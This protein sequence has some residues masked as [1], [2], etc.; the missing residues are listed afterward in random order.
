MK[1]LL[2]IYTWSTVENKKKNENKLVVSSRLSLAESRKP[3][4]YLLKVGVWSVYIL[5]SPSPTCGIILVFVA[6]QGC[7]S[8]ELVTLELKLSIFYYSAGLI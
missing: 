4:L 3:P 1:I 6:L 2:G 7:V 8:N 5:S